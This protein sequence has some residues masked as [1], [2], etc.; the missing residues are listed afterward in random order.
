MS[1]ADLSFVIVG[2]SLTVAK[3]FPPPRKGAF[4]VPLTKETVFTVEGIEGTTGLEGLS[5]L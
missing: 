3:G 5:S 1:G 2:F 4:A